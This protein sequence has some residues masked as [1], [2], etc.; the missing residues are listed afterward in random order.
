MVFESASHTGGRHH[1]SACAIWAATRDVTDR[2]HSIYGVHTMNI[3]TV[4]VIRP[5]RV[6]AGSHLDGLTLEEPAWALEG[7]HALSVADARKAEADGYCEILSV[8][9]QREVWSACCTE[10]QA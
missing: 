7:Q 5:I 10:H 9:G 1:R 3:A 8:D 6:L 2:V 4:A